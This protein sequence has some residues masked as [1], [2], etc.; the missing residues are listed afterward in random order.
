MGTFR[1][2]SPEPPGK[3]LRI[4]RPRRPAETE[5]ALIRCP[6]CESARV[7]VVVSPS[8]KA[9]CVRCGARW[10]QE[11]SLQRQVRFSKP[12]TA[13]ALEPLAGEPSA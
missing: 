5:V 2:P 9:F 12:T 13:G 7:V 3:G 11:G 10:V 4:D 1:S 8:P 6:A